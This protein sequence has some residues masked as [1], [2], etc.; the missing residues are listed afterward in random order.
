M[1]LLNL[2]DYHNKPLL[3]TVLII[4]TVVNAI[5]LAFLI[6]FARQPE[7][8]SAE[9]VAAANTYEQEEY[10]IPDNLPDKGPLLEL[11]DEKVR[12]K[13]GDEFDYRK[14]IETALDRNGKDMTY[15]V[16]LSGDLNMRTLQ[17]SSTKSYI[18]APVS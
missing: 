18:F 17:N 8:A 9:A 7:A 13:V 1:D 16:R 4:L 3:R 12:L 6:F 10:E 5:V 11:T 15:H 14:Y 2:F